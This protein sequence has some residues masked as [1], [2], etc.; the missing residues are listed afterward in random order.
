MTPLRIFFL[1][2]FGLDCAEVAVH[3]HPFSEIPPEN[4]GGRVLFFGQITD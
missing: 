2:I 3:S 1:E 4:T